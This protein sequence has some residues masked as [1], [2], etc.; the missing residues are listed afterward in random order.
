MPLEIYRN[1]NGKIKYAELNSY[2][3][4]RHLLFLYAGGSLESYDIME[5]GYAEEEESFY[6]Q[7]IH[8]LML[9]ERSSTPFALIDDIDREDR[10][11][12]Y[13]GG[14]RDHEL[15]VILPRRGK[16]RILSARFHLYHR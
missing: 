13:K 16:L 1:I 3:R 11:L 15:L 2:Q 8:P 10:D 14:L 7:V 12:I 4:P 5:I 6:T 9:N